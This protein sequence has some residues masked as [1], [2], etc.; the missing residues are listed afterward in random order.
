[1]RAARTRGQRKYR[2]G[3]GVLAARRSCGGIRRGQDGFR[4][5]GYAVGALVTDDVVP[6]RSR[7]W[8]QFEARKAA[9]AR[10]QN[11]RRCRL[12]RRGRESGTQHDAFTGIGTP[13]EFRAHMH[14]FADAGVDQVIFLQQGGKNRHEHI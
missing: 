7:L 10:G 12:R 3:L 6:G 8:E 5:F 2:D 11:V 14:G 9:R 13:D 1:M 4:F